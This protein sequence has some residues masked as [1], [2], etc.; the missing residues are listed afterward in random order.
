MPHNCRQHG[1]DGWGFDC[2]LRTVRQRLPTNVLC[3]GPLWCR[4]TTEYIPVVR[5]GEVH[6]QT[7]QLKLM[8]GGIAPLLGQYLQPK[9]T[10]GADAVWGSERRWPGT[11]ALRELVWENVRAHKAVDYA[12]VQR[13]MAM[14]R[15]ASKVGLPL[16]NA[17]DVLKYYQ[18]VWVEGPAPTPKEAAS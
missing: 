14:Q 5:H 18:S 4:L 13:Y 17:E 8:H 9:G 11:Q 2:S 3:Y 7:A 10:R 1:A 12:L 6:L 16:I 15:V